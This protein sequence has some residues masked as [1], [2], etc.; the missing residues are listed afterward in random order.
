MLFERIWSSL[1]MKNHKKSSFGKLKSIIVISIML[2]SSTAI[3]G[4]NGNTGGSPAKTWPFQ[5]RLLVNPEIQNMLDLVSTDTLMANLENLVGFYTRQTNSDTVSSEIGI[6]ATRR[7]IFQKFTDY[8]L[9]PE[10]YGLTPD[11][12][13]FEAQVCSVPGL[14]S[15]VMGVING[16]ETPFRYFVDMGHMDSRTVNVCDS[17][18]FAPSANDDGSGTVVAMEMARILSRY[19]MESTVV[20]LVVTG[21]DQGLYGS[22]AY[23]NWAYYAGTHIEA[24]ITNDVV[25]NIEGCENPSCPDGEPVII[26]STSVRHFSGG[27]S[28]G[29]SRQ[30]TRY[31]KLKAMEYVDGFEVDLIP[32]LDRPGRSGDHVPFYNSGYPAARF[33]EAHENGDGSGNNGRQHNEFDIIS[34]MNTNAGYIANIAKINIAGIASLA[35]AP[36]IPTE[37][38]VSDMGDGHRAYLAWPNNQYE[39]DFSGY[40]IAVRTAEELFYTDIIDVGNVNEYLLDGLTDSEPVY[41][42]ISAYD[43]DENESMFSEEIEFIPHRTPAIPSSLESISGESGTILT[44][45]LNTE[46]DIAGYEIYRA[47]PGQ[48]EPDSVGYVIHPDA[49][50]LDTD[51]LPHIIYSYF[52]SAVDT[53]GIQSELSQPVYGQK[54]SHDLGILIIDGT[55][56]GGGNPFQPTDQQVDDFYDQISAGFNITA[57]WD[58]ADSIQVGHAV[59]DAELAPYSAVIMHSDRGGALHYADTTAFR[60]YLQ[61]GGNM[62]VSGWNLGLALTGNSSEF[63]FFPRGTFCREFLKVDSI[64][65]SST[66]NRDFV[67]APS[68]LQGIY[69]DLVIDSVKVPLFDNRLFRMEAIFGNWQGDPSIDATNYY[70]SYLGDDFELHGK[71]VAMRYLGDDFRLVATDVPL[72]FLKSDCATQYVAVALGDLGEQTTGVREDTDLIQPGDFGITKVYPNPFNSSVAIS[73]T[74]PVDGSIDLTIYNILGQK[75]STIADGQWQAGSHTVSW[76]AGNMPTGIYFVTINSSGIHEST[77]I[78]LIK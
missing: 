3:G 71:P 17:V 23:A 65:V 61:N 12:F 24:A 29:L 42:S 54:A 35:L 38:T 9:D 21:E 66:Q 41:I 68:L 55:L 8:S 78:S 26:D 6:G 57:R 28:T 69:P 59:S 18:S 74:L 48:N 25:G 44:W 76:N 63:L 10:A 49:E 5:S 58:I 60:K 62:L 40:R 73:F 53:E 43:T 1:K 31:M 19:P 46:I 45:S 13:P 64:K 2:V 72:Y 47:Q 20:I 11:Y 51:M 67:S 52:I 75:I 70:N 4:S 14:H 34:P 7:W 15:N 56:D 33:T 39:P 16:T 32:A 37:L 27:P 30:L 22:A 50:W 36:M 77:R